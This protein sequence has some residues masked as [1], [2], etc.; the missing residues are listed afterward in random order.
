MS[1]AKNSKN[2]SPII[3]LLLAMKA[4]VEDI[5]VKAKDLIEKTNENSKLI[6]K[7]RE[8]YDSVGFKIDAIS[9]ELDKKQKALDF[10][11]DEPARRQREAEVEKEILK[12]IFSFH[13]C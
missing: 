6:E 4:Q 13:I 11:K 9:I 2:E 10:I 5:E 12:N 1:N 3:K 8:M 7:V